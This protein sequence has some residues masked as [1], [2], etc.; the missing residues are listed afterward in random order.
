M[1]VS[2]LFKYIF[3]IFVII[4]LCYAG[5]KLYENKENTVD[6]SQNTVQ[7][8]ETDDTIKDI[9]LGL[10][11]YDTINP[12]IT[13]NREILNID[14]L[15]Y[16]PLFTIT[17]DYQLN[18]CLATEWSKTG[19]STY[20]VKI[21]T[22]IKWQDGAYLTAKDVQFTID[23]LKEGNSIYKSNVSHV[24]SV[25]V[26]DS[27][28][29]K[30][31]LDQAEPFFEYNLTFPIMSNLYY[32]D[33]DFYTSNKVPI[34]TGRFKIS[35]ISS[36]SI[37]LS[38]NDS[39]KNN[40]KDGS[41]IDTIK[42]NLYSSMGGVFNAF[43]LGNIDI[44]NTTTQNYGDYVGTIGLN[45]TQ[46]SGRQFDFLS[47]NCKDSILQDKYVRQAISYAIDKDN[48]ISAVYNNQKVSASYPLDY[49]N[50][51]F[52]SDNNSSGYNQE[53]SKQILQNNGWSYNN[54]KWKRNTDY[55]TL[56]LKLSVEKDNSQRVQV[57]ELIKEQLANIGIS[58]TIDKLSNNEYQ[59][60][61]ANKDYQLLLTGVYNSYS[62]DL[63]YFFGSGNIENYQNDDI[64]SILSTDLSSKNEKSTKENYNKIYEIYKDEVPFVGL[65]RN[66]NI[67]IS[68]KSLVGDII[69]N[70]YS[71]F[72]NIAQWY[73]R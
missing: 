43:K 62:P 44:L 2:T 15:V 57:A 4:I 63:S 6:D 53:Q 27:S 10:C 60:C 73:R 13:T 45:A 28:T 65:Y 17:K 9:R 56:K 19:D 69:V 8:S 58:V 31:I 20:I 7:T 48:I 59:D 51:L 55:V 67:T 33:T 42:I 40:E 72:Y 3:A 32:F 71:S 54:N 12:L 1:R 18:P 16:E 68:S 5:Y 34:G 66:K 26:I 36:T 29:I 30:I 37:T 11:N 21:D 22:T 61:L 39:W 38:K 25:E 24:S 47:I 70:N 50:Y 14:T 64:L 35:D 41:K 23:K 49:G 52:T 46:T